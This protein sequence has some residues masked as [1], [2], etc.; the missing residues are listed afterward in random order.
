[1]T[2]EY[3]TALPIV[4]A[5]ALAARNVATRW[6]RSGLGASTSRHRETTGAQRS[7]NPERDKC[8]RREWTESSSFSRRL[9][10]REKPERAFS[11]KSH[12]LSCCVSF[13]LTAD[14]FNRAESSRAGNE[15][16]AF[17]FFDRSISDHSRRAITFVLFYLWLCDS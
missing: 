1:M 16:L 11:W 6:P 5:C 7:G 17:P 4:R 14:S 15:T 2:R 12:S 8:V 9:L 10:A 13:H 3:A